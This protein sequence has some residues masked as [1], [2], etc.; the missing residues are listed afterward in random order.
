MSIGQPPVF[1]VPGAS[2]GRGDAGLRMA[3]R[4]AS[5]TRPAVRQNEVVAALLERIVSGA[6]APSA[7]VPTRTELMAEF[8][9]S[10]ITLQR[11][12]DDLAELGLIVA[13]G[14]QG[15]F[16]ADRLPH[17]HGIALLFPTAPG[18]DGRWSRFYR[19]L[20]REAGRL[21]GESG[22]DITCWNALVEGSRGPEHERLEAFLAKRLFAG[23]IFA[24]NP[25]FHGE[26]S[27]YLANPL[28]RVA[29]ADP[30]PE[31]TQP[32][33]LDGISY[34]DRLVA[35]LR[36]H[37]RT[38]VAIIAA[39]SWPGEGFIARL[40]SEGFD[41][42]PQWVQ[43]LD[44]KYP[45]KASAPTRLLFAP[46][47]SERP[48]ALLIVDDH[49]EEPVIAG[50]LAEGVHIGR[51]VTVVAHANFPRDTRSPDDPVIRI[52]YHAGEILARSIEALMA[53]G[54]A[55][56]TG[57]GPIAIPAHV[58]GDAVDTTVHHLH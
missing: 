1:V 56:T 37:G 49:F 52:G 57:R 4:T 51:D 43:S 21:A 10:S 13:C 12:F 44:L 16:V 58:E 29:I 55:R 25:A 27:L 7:R 11:A 39:A 20:E 38:R 47:A 46:W 53:A 18:R 30:A 17:R 24:Y 50:L 34:A 41:V 3:K 40:R 15:T 32:V 8:D 42:R 14:S 35:I 22:L 19:G 26:G 31:G 9:V 28:P 48:D 36:Q 33:V 2:T 54:G 23:V 6:L 5:R 45:E